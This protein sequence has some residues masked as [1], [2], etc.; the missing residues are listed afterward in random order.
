[1]KNLNNLLVGLFT[2]VI[3][4]FIVIGGVS[5]ALAEGITPTAVPTQPEPELSMPTF[6]PPVAQSNNQIYPIFTGAPTASA[7]A[8]LVIPTA[9]PPPKGWQPYTIQIGDTLQALANRS[10]TST[11]KL[12]QANCLLIDTLLPDTILYVPPA[13]TPKPS[14]TLTRMPLPSFTSIPCGPPASWVRYIVKQN[15]TLYKLS[16]SLGISIFQLQNANC[17]GSSQFIMAGETLYVPYIQNIQA[18]TLTFTATPRPTAIKN[19]GAPTQA[20][21]AKTNI[22]TN[23]KI[24]TEIT[25][26]SPVPAATTQPS[27]VPTDTTQTSLVPTGITP[28]TVEPTAT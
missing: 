21:P 7:T 8:T 2:A 16:L 9:C 14:A 26:P 12:S 22:P 3:S 10:G 17:L 6:A 13:P 5:L 24:P 25:P 23:T 19:T 4:S 28:P 18:A 20:L 1:M 27:P 11:N 15:D